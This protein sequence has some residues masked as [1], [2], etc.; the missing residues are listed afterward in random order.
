MSLRV[1]FLKFTQQHLISFL[2]VVFTEL[3]ESPIYDSARIKPPIMMRP[4]SRGQGRL[5]Y[6]QK[7]IDKY[8]QAVFNGHV[9]MAPLDVEAILQLVYEGLT[10]QFVKKEQSSCQQLKETLVF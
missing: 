2:P 1:F 8:P 7:L 10:Y 9:S 3:I 4:I 5:R 6:I